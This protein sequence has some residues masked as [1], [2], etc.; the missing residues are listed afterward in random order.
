MQAPY[1]E[2]HALFAKLTAGLYRSLVAR[3]EE[4]FALEHESWLILHRS[5]VASLEVVAADDFAAE[6]TASDARSELEFYTT[7]RVSYVKDAFRRAFCLFP[8]LHE[9]L[10]EVSGRALDLARLRALCDTYDAEQTHAEERVMS[11]DNAAYLTAALDRLR[12]LKA[13]REGSP[14]RMAQCPWLPATA[15][16]AVSGRAQAIV[17]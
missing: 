8:V 5:P 1:A 6:L 2:D 12:Q 16:P 10:E 3:F 9:R 11:P 7:L 14:E 17:G 15:G 4:R 13:G